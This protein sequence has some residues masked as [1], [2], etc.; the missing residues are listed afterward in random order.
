MRRL[1]K[2]TPLP[3]P[4]PTSL[5]TPLPTPPPTRQYVCSRI[6]SSRF[7]PSYAEKREIAHVTKF[8]VLFCPFTLRIISISEKRGLRG[9]SS[10][11]EITSEHSPL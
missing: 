8:G 10:G 1:I 3:T 5:P 4:L 6:A 7:S 2:Y 11:R 9:V